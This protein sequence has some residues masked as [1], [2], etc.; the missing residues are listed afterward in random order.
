MAMTLRLT[1]TEERALSLLADS[2]GLTKADA[3][4][5]AIMT[6]ATRMLRDEE[7]RQAA[8]EELARYGL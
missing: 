2:W 8:R 5:R 7:A 6:A 1:P 4:R 3:A